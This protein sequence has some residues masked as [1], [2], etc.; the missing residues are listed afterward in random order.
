MLYSATGGHAATC[1]SEPLV[2]QDAS[3]LT[4]TMR[5]SSRGLQHGFE[6]FRQPPGALAGASERE[7]EQEDSEANGAPAERRPC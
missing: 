2:A 5:P 3:K 6:A 1:D 4:A 7:Q